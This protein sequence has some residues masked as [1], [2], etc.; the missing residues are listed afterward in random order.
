MKGRLVL[1]NPKRSSQMPGFS[2]VV[3]ETERGIAIVGDDWIK[4]LSSAH[5]EDVTKEE[6]RQSLGLTA[7]T[8]LSLSKSRE[9]PDAYHMSA[10]FLQFLNNWYREEV[11]NLSRRPS[12]AK[13]S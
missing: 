8:P 2:P 3:M 7:E 5:L 10:P 12:L 11:E 4:L 13:A 6:V 9:L 1:I